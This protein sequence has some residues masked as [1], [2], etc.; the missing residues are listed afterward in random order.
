MEISFGIN[1]GRRSAKNLV[2]RDVLDT[3]AIQTKVVDCR[4]DLGRE[5]VA[6]F[7]WYIVTFG[8]NTSLKV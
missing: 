5:V 1:D 4:M 6:D 7:I 8:I 2:Q 3:L